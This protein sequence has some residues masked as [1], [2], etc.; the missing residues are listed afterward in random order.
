MD[1][2]STFRC[3]YQ[4][5]SQ[6]LYF[7]YRFYLF[8]VQTKPQIEKFWEER[9]Q[10]GISKDQGKSGIASQFV[11]EKFASID[12]SPRDR[13][14]LEVPQR[15]VQWARRGRGRTPYPTL[16]QTIGKSGHVR[17]HPYG[18]IST[19]EEDLEETEGDGNQM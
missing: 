8:Q 4:S 12:G 1:V 13:I 10:W 18:A 6:H 16:C 2:H 3:P 9:L 5:V 17:P 7:A 11:K 15:S 19:D 14:N